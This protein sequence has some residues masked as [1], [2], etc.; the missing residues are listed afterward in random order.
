MDNLNSGEQLRFRSFL[1]D[2][3]REHEIK[4][5]VDAGG[6]C[7]WLAVPRCQLGVWI[8]CGVNNLQ[9]TVW[10]SDFSAECQMKTWWKEASSRVF[11]TSHRWGCG[12][13][14]SGYQRHMNWQD[15]KYTGVDVVPYVVEENARYFEAKMDEQWLG[16]E[17]QSGF[18][19]FFKFEFKG[20]GNNFEDHHFISFQS[21]KWTTFKA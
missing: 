17:H 20:F 16:K 5:V 13:W 6:R 7:G 15:V 21:A 8:T 12:H 14:P 2:F 10:E 1:E 9:K 18:D 4:S 19:Y 11:T 3:L